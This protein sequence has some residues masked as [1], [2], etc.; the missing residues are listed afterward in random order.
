MRRRKKLVRFKRRRRRWGH[1]RCFDY[2]ASSFLDAVHHINQFFR[3]RSLALSLGFH[4]HSICMCT[5]CKAPQQ[6]FCIRTQIL[7]SF[8]H[9]VHEK[10]LQ[11]KHYFGDFRLCSAHSSQKTWMA[12]AVC[13]WLVST[14]YNGRALYFFRLAFSMQTKCVPSCWMEFLTMCRCR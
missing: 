9:R 12:N 1:E 4:P 7:A 14:M 3:S 6:V 11:L 13:M 8:S 5:K 10:N 2:I